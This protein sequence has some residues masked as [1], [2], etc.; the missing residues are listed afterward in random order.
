[1]TPG[2]SP[3]G[4]NSGRT[5]KGT[6]VFPMAFAFQFFLLPN[7]VSASFFAQKKQRVEEKKMKKAAP[8]S[9]HSGTAKSGTLRNGR[10]TSQI[11]RR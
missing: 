7:K 6:V 9:V 2:A 3:K 10:I 4:V 8:E 11:L 1:M 5:L